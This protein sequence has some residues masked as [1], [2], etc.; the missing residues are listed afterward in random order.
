MLRV[1]ICDE[2]TKDREAVRKL[3]F[4]TLFSYEE[5][6]F[7]EYADA[8]T[9]EQEIEQD[10]AIFDLLLMEVEYKTK[11]GLK[12]AE[13]I[14]AKKMDADIL[15]VTNQTDAAYE[16]YRLQA[17]AYILKSKMEDML[18]AALHRY[19]ER[20]TGEHKLTVKTEDMTKVINISSILY[21]ESDVRTLLLHTTNEVIRSHGKLKEIEPFLLPYGFIRIHQSYLVQK[22][23]IRGIRNYELEIGEMTLPISRRYYKELRQCFKPSGIYKEWESE[24]ALTVT[25]SYALQMQED[26]GAVIGTKGE[27]LGITYRMKKGECLKIGRDGASCQILLTNPNTSRVHCL[28]YRLADGS[29]RIEDCSK[30]GVYVEGELVGRGNK[31]VAASGQRVWICSETTEFRLG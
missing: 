20:L 9:L 3:T 14:R 31:R 29:Y 26:N 8:E 4:T 11:Q 19:M 23:A 27:M 13:M 28:V 2:D 10:T 25:K 16:G 6:S 15:F 24:E 17:F 7:V 12:L 1:A 18:P 5:I 22:S 30:N 21:V